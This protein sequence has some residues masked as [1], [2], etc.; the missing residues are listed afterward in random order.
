M[1]KNLLRLAVAAAVGVSAVSAAAPV[2]QNV[3]I[4][5]GFTAPSTGGVAFSA[6]TTFGTVKGAN[7]LTINPSSLTLLSVSYEV[8]GFS[9]V[10]YT[11]TAG[12][13]PTVALGAATL[14]VKG[15]GGSPVLSP[16]V[17]IAATP[18]VL[19]VPGTITAGPIVAGPVNVLGGDLPSYAI[20]GPVSFSLDSTGFAVAQGTDKVTATLEA[21]A[22]ATV[23]VTYT[24]SD[25]PEASTYAALGFLGLAG[26]FT[27]LRRRQ[28]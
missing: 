28:A 2:V 5:A 17:S 9:Y 12:I 3:T 7:D 4:P 25:V 15:P 1:N 23:K 18:V 22:G 20:A 19:N 13:N 24:Y 26:G 27:Y 14:T 16:N 10:N 21:F 6:A 11:V 8:S